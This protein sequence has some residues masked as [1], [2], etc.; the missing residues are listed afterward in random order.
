MGGDTLAPNPKF[1]WFELCNSP[2]LHPEKLQELMIFCPN[3]EL[4]EELIDSDKI[5]AIIVGGDR[6]YCKIFFEKLMK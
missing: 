2:R 5:Q 1:D 6:I 3:C 4:K